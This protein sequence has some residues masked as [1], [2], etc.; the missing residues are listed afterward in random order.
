MGSFPEP[1]VRSRSRR[2]LLQDLYPGHSVIS[3]SSPRLRSQSR[4]A[5][6]VPAC[7]GTTL[8]RLDA[9]IIDQFL[10]ERDDAGRDHVVAMIA[11]FI[12]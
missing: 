11:W 10:V 2:G 6:P 8:R 1:A 5:I 9:P 12:R 4:S 3:G 7:Q